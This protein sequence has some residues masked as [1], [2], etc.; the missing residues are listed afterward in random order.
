MKFSVD[1]ARNTEF[2]GKIKINW[3]CLNFQSL[4]MHCDNKVRIAVQIFRHSLGIQKF[5]IFILKG[6]EM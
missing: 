5:M 4:C 6:L 3:W 1:Q 2:V